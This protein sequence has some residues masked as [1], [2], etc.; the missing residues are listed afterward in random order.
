MRYSRY[1][2]LKHDGYIVQQFKKI[3]LK[4]FVE[5]YEIGVKTLVVIAKNIV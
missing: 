3:E 1:L 2:S 4:N 5:E